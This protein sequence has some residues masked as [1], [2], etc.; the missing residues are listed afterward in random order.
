MK[1]K[2]IKKSTVS[3]ACLFILTDFMP[4]LA[5]ESDDSLKVDQMYSLSLEQLMQV[6]VV[7]ASRRTQRISEAPS[8]ISAF[9]RQDIDNMSVTSLIDVIKHAPGIETSMDPDGHWRV[10]IR[11]VRKDG[12]ILLLIDGQPF[13]D[14][15]DGRALFDLPTEFIDR[16][17]IIRGPGSALYGTNAVAGIINVFTIQE[18]NRASLSIG[19]NTTYRT[20]FSHHTEFGNE[21]ILSISVGASD[22]DGAN[23]TDD[24]DSADGFGL[25]TGTTNR[26]KR[27]LFLTT[28]YSQ[29]NLKLS[30]MGFRQRRGPWAGP[31]FQWG[32]ET[33]VDKSQY[34]LRFIYRFE[35]SESL[36]ITPRIH[37]DVTD[38]DALNEDVAAGRTLLGNTFTESGF[39]RESYKTLNIG[40]E[41]LAEYSHNENTFLLGGF[42]FENT[43]MTNFDLQRNYRVIGFIPRANFGNHDNLTFEQNN[44]DRQ[45]YAVFGQAEF[46]W[47]ALSFTLGTRLDHYSSF[48]NSV[49]PRLGLVYHASEKLRIKALF[50]SAF[51][52]PTFKELYDNTRIGAEGIRGNNDLKPEESQSFELALEY[53]SNSY[54]LKLN[55]YDTRNGNVIGSFDPSGGGARATTENI[56]DIDI[57]GAEVEVTFQLS[58]SGQMF[59]N[60]AR[61]R[62]YF[63]WSSGS[64]FDNQRRFLA[65]RGQNELFNQPRTR[66]NL[67]LTLSGNNWKLFASLNYGGKASNNSTSPI[68]SL[69]NLEVDAYVHFSASIRYQFNSKLGIKFAANNLG[70]EKNSDPEGFEQSE[71]FGFKG[72]LQPDESYML[73]L[74]YRF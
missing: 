27:E 67:G 17:E 16:I 59:F 45:I 12:N 73:T 71:N 47:R 74:D 57:K 4:S 29:N 5:A 13:N 25:D 72:I 44:Q 49:N 18:Q 66:A 1:S 34:Y 56:G 51:R 43:K 53:Q 50:G 38:H 6:R 52:A 10:S 69:R 65:G 3:I 58:D 30:L 21:A 7:T 11:G 36:S 8:I 15:Y 2:T 37:L 39:T 62:S 41:I 31:Q 28:A 19:N 54:L 42:G 48:G 23:V 46:Q 26:H 9:G 22:T 64:L 60:L 35:P 24:Q 63:N 68:A 20:S 55:L 40:T 32:P 33:R 14:F 70:D 61:Y